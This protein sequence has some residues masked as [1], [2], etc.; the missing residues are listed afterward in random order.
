MIRRFSEEGRVIYL[1]KQVPEQTGFDIR[2][3]FYWALH[4]G[5]QVDFQGITTADHEEY[6]VFP[7]AAID[8]LTVLPGVHAIDPATLLCKKGG[9]CDLEREGTLIYRDPSH[10]S[11]FG[12]MGLESLFTPMFKAMNASG[13]MQ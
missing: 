12:A 8:A 11:T 5:R 2:D 3:S 7:S 6:Q 10:L 13:T 4:T 1:I 9:H